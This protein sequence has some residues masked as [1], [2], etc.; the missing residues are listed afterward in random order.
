MRRRNARGSGA[1]KQSTTVQVVKLQL[2]FILRF[3]RLLVGPQRNL[4]RGTYGVEIIGSY[5]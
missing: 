2:R 3:C 4:S 1:R 5:G